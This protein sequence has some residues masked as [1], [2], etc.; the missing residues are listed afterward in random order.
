MRKMSKLSIPLAVAAALLLLARGAPAEAPVAITIVDFD[1][2]DTSSEPKDQ[3]AA[4]QR[5]LQGF[6]QSLRDDIARGGKYRIVAATCRT[7]PCSVAT[8]APAELIDASRK[9][10]A[11]LLLYGGTHKMSTLVQWGK[12][13]MVDVETGKL[14]Y[15]RLLTFRGDDDAAW[16]RAE[17]FLAK[18]VEAQPL[19]R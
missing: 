10:G 12:V 1:Y 8:S 18:D 11:T 3:T 13:E 17:E 15:D 5:R 6:M 14:V 16:R 4:H 7:M 19:P 2:L 9:A